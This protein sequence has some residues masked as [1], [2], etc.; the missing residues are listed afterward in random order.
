MKRSDLAQFQ[1]FV[2]DEAVKTGKTITVPEV[3]LWFETFKRAT[4]EDFKIA[5]TAHKRD[6]KQ[7]GY[8]PTINQIQ[9]LLRMEGEDQVQRDWRCAEEVSGQ[10]CGFPG[11]IKLQGSSA[12]YC[13]AHA[14][15]KGSESYSE[16]ASLQIIEQSRSYMPPK[17]AMELMERGAE[18]R[19]IEGERWRKAHGNPDFRRKSGDEVRPRLPQKTE[20]PEVDEHIAATDEAHAREVNEALALAGQEHSA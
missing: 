14:R 4:L 19:A 12:C 8:F 1:D 13:G 11:A 2:L 10:R 17:T 3:D 20:A 18:Q 16:S 7:G 5:W 6:P 9:R 15:L